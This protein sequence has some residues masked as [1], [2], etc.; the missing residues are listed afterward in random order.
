[1]KNIIKKQNKKLKSYTFD[2]VFAK[3]FKSK[4]FKDSY[5][6]EIVRLEVANQIKQIRLGSNLTQKEVAGRAKMP[7]SVIARIESGTHSFSLGTLGRI[8][9]VLNK[10]IELA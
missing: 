10:K 9:K 4:S 2:Q 6:E 7:Q 3:S 5:N 8:A 1:M